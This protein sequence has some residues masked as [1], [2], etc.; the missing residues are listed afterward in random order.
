MVSVLLDPQALAGYNINLNQLQQALS[1]ANSVRDNLSI[2]NDNQEV[3]IQ[4][5]TFLTSPE[6]VGDLV[7]GLQDGIPVYLRDVATIKHGPD[8]PSQYVWIGSGPGSSNQTLSNS[9]SLP[10]VTIAIAKKPGTNAVDIANAVIERFEQL[11]GIFIPDGVHA[12][13]TRNYEQPLMPR[14]RN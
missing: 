7:V 13:I 1:A 11:D 10:A 14:P 4:S 3:L 2:T 5:G 8:Q 9:D 6:Q 12:S